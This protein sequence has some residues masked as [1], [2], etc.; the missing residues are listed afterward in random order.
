MSGN[1]LTS[2]NYSEYISVSGNDW[3]IT[4]DASNSDLYN[5]KE[6]YIMYMYS[7][8]IGQSYLRFDYDASG[9]T[10]GDR[11]GVEFLLDND[12]VGRLK[13]MYNGTTITFDA[14]TIIKIFYKT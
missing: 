14:G 10:L 2:D 8:Y 4:S 6:I 1:I 7:S 9:T 11:N 3:N 12:D 5:A 13:M